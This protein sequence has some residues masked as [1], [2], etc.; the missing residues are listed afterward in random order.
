MS[1]RAFTVVEQAIQARPVRRSALWSLL[2]LVAL[3]LIDLAISL[4]VFVAAYK[5]HHHAPVLIWKHKRSVL[6]IG[7]WPNFAPYF[8]LMLFVPFVKLYALRRYGLYKL[9]GEFSFSGDLIK[10]FNAVTLA[11]LILVLIAFLFRQGF[12]F[13]GGHVQLLDFTYSRMVFIYDWLLSLGAFWAVRSLVRVWQTLARTSE[14]NL[15]PTIVVGSGEMAQV[16][17]A[18]ISEKPRLGYKLVGTVTARNSEDTAPIRK[19]GARALGA[20]D[21]LP[22]LV[23]KYNVEEVLITD[24]RIHPRKMFEVLMECG[25]DHHIKY[26]VIPNLFDC[27]PGKTEIETIGSLPMIKLYEEPLRGWLRAVKRGLDGM[28]AL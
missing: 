1:E 4:A 18:E 3:V 10:I 5:L 25:R 20:F 11:F 9:R 27:L 19:Y 13:E 12:T 8:T 15:I 2:P 6:P 14:S 7:V 16:C 28:V 22:A 21:D 17:I 24:P 23:K 26:R